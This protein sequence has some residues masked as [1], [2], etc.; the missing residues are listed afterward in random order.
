MPQR[1]LLFIDASGL[2]AYRWQEGHIL[3]EGQFAAD[4]TGRGAFAEYLAG[5]RSG[6]FYLVAD[7]ADEGFQ[8]E[9]IPHVQGR[10]RT[11]LIRRKLGQYFYGTP[12][13]LAVSL[14]RDKAGRRD[15]KMLF[16][17]LTRPQHLEPWLDALRRA[18]LP[19]AG[20]YSMPMALTAL[21]ATV[22]RQHHQFLMISVSRSG[23]RQ[24]LIQDGK[25][26]FS[27]LTPLATGSVE[28]TS[29]ATA[30]E[31]SKIYQYLAAQRLISRS[32]TL[33][34]LV[35]SHPHQAE[36]FRARCQDNDELRFELVDLVAEASHHG[37]K[38]TPVDSRGEKLFLHLLVRHSPPHQFAPDEERRFYRLWQLRFA[39]RS[40]GMVALAASLLVAA[41]Y[42]IDY[43]EREAQTEQLQAQVEQ[44]QRR[45][46]G[47]LQTL[48]KVPL[49]ADSLRVLIDRHDELARRNP[50]PEP[51]YWRISQALHDA[52][53]V[54]LT[55]LNWVLSPQ[56][57][58]EALPAA[59]AMRPTGKESGGADS[60]FAIVDLHG[61]LPVSMVG[62]HRA[63]R[64]AIENFAERLRVDP[65]L[66]VRI[67][68]Q[69][70]EIDPAKVLKSG[71]NTAARLEAPKFSLRLV[72]KL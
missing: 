38:T 41:K 15:E 11:A 25:L 48:P 65:A 21:A 67:L 4:E 62:N 69:P 72:Q 3:E 2:A 12:L 40:I 58:P 49:S 55:R 35:L 42:S 5:H 37:L 56:P 51:M 9:D 60:L 59:G 43:Y 44:S 14:G 29:M 20:L 24:T 61:T 23:L 45:Y 64:E 52:P 22:G 63:Q 32:A 18:E 30:I 6:I 68:S 50:G 19:L 8:I 70:F 53:K 46:N 13:T 16:A 10:D 28:E 17:A 1:R 57:D 33:P 54:E 66:R 47:I 26:R 36:A 39:L 7:V 31:S 34:V 27:R 71:E